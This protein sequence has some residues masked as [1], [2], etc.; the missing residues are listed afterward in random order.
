[1]VVAYESDH[2]IPSSQEQLMQRTLQDNLTIL[3]LEP[4]SGKTYEPQV[5]SRRSFQPSPKHVTFAEKEIEIS[6]LKAQLMHSNELQ[7]YY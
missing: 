1:M 2:S 3:E 6:N 5:R 4:D 7:I